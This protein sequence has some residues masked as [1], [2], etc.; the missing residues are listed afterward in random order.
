MMKIY[1]SILLCFILI[2]CQSSAKIQIVEQTKI[3]IPPEE[4][5]QCPELKNYPNPKTL[6]NYQVAQII[7]KLAKNNSICRN[8]IEAIENY[9][10]QARENAK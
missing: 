5:F 9:L 2:G 6:T 3:V 7:A 1:G 10:I 4:L 8:N